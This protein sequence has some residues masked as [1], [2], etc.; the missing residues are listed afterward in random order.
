[1]TKIEPKVEMTGRYELRDAAAVLEVDKSTILRWT[2]DGKINCGVRR[3]NKRKF[4]LGAELVKL[5]RS[6]F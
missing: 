4:W 3:S 2:R 6:E 1:M 5:W